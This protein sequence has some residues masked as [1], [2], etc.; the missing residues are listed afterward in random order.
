MPEH[1]DGPTG[2]RGKWGQPGVP[3]RGWVC[4]GIEDLGEPLETCG[5]CETMTIRYVHLMAHEDY[6]EELACGCI[7]SGHM[8]QDIEAAKVRETTMKNR[9]R[10]REAWPD[11]RAWRLSRSGNLTI[12]KDG[13]RVTVFEAG[14]GYRVSVGRQ[15]SD[16]PRFGRRVY[17]DERKAMLASFD[18]FMWAKENA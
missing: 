15:F 16:K 4:Q 2:G 6:P 8:E 10:R 1:M 7:C 12:T 5:M 18:A 3:K 14:R 11:L 17:E 13:Y 9:A